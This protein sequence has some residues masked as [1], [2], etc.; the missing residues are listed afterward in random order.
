MRRESHPFIPEG[1]RNNMYHYYQCKTDPEIRT[2]L[3][4]RKPPDPTVTTAH[5]SCPGSAAV[6]PARPVTKSAP[7]MGAVTRNVTRNV[8]M[9]TREDNMKADSKT[10]PAL[11]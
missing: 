10:L 6:Q 7:E 5:A 8:T 9:V 11:E 4:A 3:R 1:V 2:L